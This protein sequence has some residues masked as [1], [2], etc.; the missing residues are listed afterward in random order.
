MGV[1]MHIGAVVHC[2]VFYMDRYLKEVSVLS[3]RHFE[4]AEQTEP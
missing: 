2:C 1:L 3:A 4:C